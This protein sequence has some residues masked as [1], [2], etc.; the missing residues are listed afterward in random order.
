M[1]KKLLIE[2]HD[3]KTIFDRIKINDF[4]SYR[5][6]NHKI[7]LKDNDK[8]MSKSKIYQMSTHKLLEIKKYLEK[9]L[10][11]DFINFSLALFAFSILFVAKLNEELR[12][13]VNYRKLNALIRRNRYSISLIEKTLARVM[14][15]KYLIKLNIIVAFNKLRMHLDSENYITFVISIRVY[16]YHVFLFD[17]INELANY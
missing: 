3:L 16:K 13:C 12:F 1:L 2:Y 4:S 6:Y 5:L 10:K 15:C 11:K 7:Q 14:S 9:N 17:L 8:L